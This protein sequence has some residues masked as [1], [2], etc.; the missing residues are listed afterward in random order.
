[1]K[2]LLVA[3]TFILIPFMGLAQVYG[4]LGENTETFNTI[5]FNG[6][7]TILAYGDTVW[8]SPE[9]NRNIGNASEWFRPEGADSVTDNVGRVYSLELGQDTVLAG[10]GYTNSD[11]EGSPQTAFGY[12]FSV[13]GGDSWRFE[14]DVTDPDPPSKC[15]SS[16]PDYEQPSSLDDYDPDCDIQ[17]TYGGVTYNR[18]RFTVPELSPP[19]EV[20]FK[21][22]VV[23]S[24][25][26]SGGLL[27]STDFGQT[28]ERVILPP[29]NV[30]E[31]TPEEDYLWSSNLSLSTGSSVQINRYDPRSDFLFNLRVFGVYIDTQNRVWV[32]TGNG[33]N[34][35]DNALTA[36][37]D[38][39]RW[40]HIV[41]DGSVD[42]LIGN[43]V[44]EIKEEPSTNRIWMTNRVIEAGVEKQGIVYTDDGG[45]TFT[46]MLVGERI[47]DI[48]FKDG[49]VFA[50]GENG[51]F[52]SSNGGDTWIK[53]PE[54][55][56]P[57]TFIKPSAVYYSA[58]S[59]N[60]R[61]WIS[62]EDGI[63]S[64]QCC[65]AGQTFDNWEI[66]RV[67]FPLKGGNIHDEGRDVNTYAYPNPF[68]PTVHELVRIKFEVKNQSTVKVRIFD[69]GM[70][71]V[72]EVE[73]NSF[74][75]GTYEAVWDGLDG[76]GR[77]VANA[78]Y[79]YVIENGSR[80]VNGK[81]L[82]VD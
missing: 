26:F 16:D 12:Y 31:L 25:N 35:S 34:V 54:I 41:F 76:K 9:L 50:T 30:S 46:Q 58:T 62:T 2:K 44:I 61:I 78:P 66:T 75:P 3:F 57:N 49:Y 52:I 36:P 14:P 37:T 59:T 8:I 48:G 4:P 27:R 74:P 72:R 45:E 69:F 70:N 71:L 17:F 7:S 24:A 40:S 13:D 42:G 80:Q 6:V 39:I 43:W 60:D 53:S 68:S 10:L 21:D 5:R 20:D 32:G 82:V 15:F 81:I 77:K 67:N 38:S 79:I 51:L 47:N 18:I 64:H 22:E 29:D 1:M 33:V 63:A 19:Y 56:S 23:F 28:W 11:A 55:R 65:T 73:N